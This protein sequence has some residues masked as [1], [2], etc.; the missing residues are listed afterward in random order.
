[1][2]P[3]STYRECAEQCL[4]LAEMMTDPGTRDSMLHAAYQWR[5]LADMA[6][7]YEPPIDTEPDDKSSR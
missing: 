2:K 3:Q 1:M 6:E 7:R 5:L 4:I